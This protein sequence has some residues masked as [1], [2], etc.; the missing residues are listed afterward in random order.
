MG[1]HGGT[2]IAGGPGGPRGPAGPGV[3]GLGP[4]VAMMPDDK[5]NGVLA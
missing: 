2:G 5:E 3:P 1:F 4:G